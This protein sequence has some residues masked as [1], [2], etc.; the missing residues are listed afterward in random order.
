[1]YTGV[2]RHTGRIETVD[3]YHDGAVVRVG[4][5]DLG[6]EPGDSVAV[7]G[8]CLTVE[9]ITDAGFRSFASDETVACTALVDRA[10]DPVNLETPVSMAEALDGHVAKGTV[11][12]TTTVERIERES[13][14][15]TWTYHVAIPDGHAVHVAPKGAV[16]LDGVSLTVDAVDDDAGTF[17]VAVVPETRERTTLSHRGAGDRV[18]F[19]ADVLARYAAR[20]SEVRT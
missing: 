2:I 11:D 5:P 20:A 8:V 6:L 15:G 18:H 13:E 17:A 14:D 3:E 7:D 4:A 16:S 10:G 9:A 1:M 19:E 12:A